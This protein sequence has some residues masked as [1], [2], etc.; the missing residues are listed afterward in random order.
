MIDK[1]VDHKPSFSPIPDA[2]PQDPFGWYYLKD[3]EVEALTPFSRQAVK[4]LL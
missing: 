2:I 4:S 3:L 1:K